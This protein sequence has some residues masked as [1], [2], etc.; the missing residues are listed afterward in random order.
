M[1]GVL[2]PQEIGAAVVGGEHRGL[3]QALVDAVGR[4]AMRALG[5]SGD[6]VK[7]WRRW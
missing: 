5:T 1:L 4:M 2:V 6:R 7:D 3:Q